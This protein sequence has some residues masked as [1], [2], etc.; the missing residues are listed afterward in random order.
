LERNLSD[1][2]EQSIV[3]RNGDAKPLADDRGGFRE[4]IAEMV[5]DQAPRVFAVVLEFGDQIDGQIVA[6]GMAFEEFAYM[7]TADGKCQYLLETPENAVRYIR[8]LSGVT[9]HVV[10]VAGATS[11]L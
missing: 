9:A 3:D 1:I 6:W 5:A 7:T 11:V 4:L 2:I 8:P 10:W